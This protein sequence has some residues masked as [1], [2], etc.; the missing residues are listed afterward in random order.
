MPGAAPVFRRIITKPYHRI[1]VP[2]PD[3]AGGRPSF[4]QLVHG[5]KPVAAQ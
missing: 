1:Q 2:T 5:G 4:R 3:T